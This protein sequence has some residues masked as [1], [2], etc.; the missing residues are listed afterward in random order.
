MKIQKL[1]VPAIMLLALAVCASAQN[2]QDAEYH[3][4]GSQYT[5]PRSTPSKAFAGKGDPHALEAAL[6]RADKQAKQQAKAAKAQK[7]VCAYCGEEILS[8]GQ[9]CAANGHNTLC[10]DQKEAP[11]QTAVRND[12]AGGDP[13]A[14]AL[15]C[16]D[17]RCVPAKKAQQPTC[18]KCGE[19]IYDRYHQECAK[20][21]KCSAWPEA[22]AQQPES[23]YVYLGGDPHNDANWAKVTKPA[24]KQQ[25]VKG[26]CAYCGEQ[27][28]SAGQH[29][30]A[31][32]Y[33]ALCSE[34]K[35]A[36]VKEQPAEEELT[37]GQKCPKCGQLIENNDQKW[38]HSCN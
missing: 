32:G 1:V 36:P 11:R 13:H 20:G 30:Q 10:S 15:D 34:T 26:K 25:A 21:D 31:Q 29:C 16:D 23:E 4:E 7:A 9:H 24:K 22:P 27:I 18:H 8:A 6:Q 14:A 5:T 19:V 12:Y 33:N 37:V 35:T 3:R 38:H 28:E 17:T 2:A